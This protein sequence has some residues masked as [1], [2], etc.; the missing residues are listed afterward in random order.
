MPKPTFFNL[1]P[2]KRQ[3]VIDAAIHEFGRH[4]F[5]QANLGRIAQAAGVSKG[6]MYQ[7]FDN[8]VDLYGWLVTVHMTE[9]KM[10]AIDTGAP[11]PGASVWKTLEFAFVSGFQ[12]AISEPDLMRLGT[13]FVRDR[14]LVPELQPIHEAQREAADVWLRALFQGGIDRG[15]L[16]RDTDVDVLLALVHRLLGDGVMDMLA[17]KVGISTSALMEDP[18]RVSA[19]SPDAARRLVRGLLR[20]LRHGAGG[21]E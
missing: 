19:L 11:E 3:R 6:S 13:R 8:K 2:D 1:D 10:A 4:P 12:F 16:A 9:R 18:G 15:E 14:A 17:R 7:Y 21:E 5:P 20:L